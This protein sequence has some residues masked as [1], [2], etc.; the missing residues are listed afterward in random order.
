[1]SFDSTFKALD[2]LDCSSLTSVSDLEDVCDC[3]KLA[4]ADAVELLSISS[5]MLL[6]GFSSA[7]SKFH[8]KLFCLVT[9]C[10]ALFRFFFLAEKTEH[11]LWAD[12]PNKLLIGFALEAVLLFD[13]STYNI[14]NHYKIHTQSYVPSTLNYEVTPLPGKN[15]LSVLF[16]LPCWILGS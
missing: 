8:R 2:T 12:F 7:F 1:M 4:V 16:S 14:W 3:F 9:V 13:V 10:Y 11:S 6:L 15:R 5:L